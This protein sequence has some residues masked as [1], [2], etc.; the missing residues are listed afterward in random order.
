TSVGAFILSFF[1]PTVGLGCRT[2]GYLVFFVVALVLLLAEILVWWLTSPLRKKDR[3]HSHVH[4]YTR[5]SAQ[6]PKDS[7]KCLSFPGLATSK[8]AISRILEVIETVI[9]WSVLS[10][11][12]LIPIRNK[13]SKLHAAENVIG[14]HFESLRGLTVRGWLQRSFFTP[15]EF[16]NMIW[17][18]YLVLAQ[19]VGAFNN[20]TCMAST[21]GSWGGYVDFT[22]W[23]QANSG[24]V[25]RYWIEGT[26]I[27]CVTMGIGMLYIVVEWLLQAHLSTEDYRDAAKGLQRVRRFRRYTHW[28]RYPSA[29]LVLLINTLL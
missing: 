23:N 15:L 3:F 5:Q 1:T 13:K 7:L 11:I 29:L 27:T 19:T 10:S 8:V 17:L 16:A 6:S 12:R 26:T 24:L 28:I 9:V 21:W 22:Q 20:C 2:G 14:H 4:A 25:E 18:C